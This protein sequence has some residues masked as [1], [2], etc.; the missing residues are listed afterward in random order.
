[1][2]I[3]DNATIKKW[4]NLKKKMY[5]LFYILNSFFLISLYGKT[6]CQ[7][8]RRVCWGS[9]GYQFSYRWQAAVLA[10]WYSLRVGGVMS[11]GS[12]KAEV[13]HV[14]VFSAKTFRELNLS[15]KCL[16]VCLWQRAGITCTAKS[17]K[18]IYQVKF[19]S[20]CRNRWVI[21][22]SHHFDAIALGP[23]LATSRRLSAKFAE[24]SIG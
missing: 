10:N 21:A 3:A 11:L 20:W 8:I 15:P 14:R 18:F 24:V 23:W 16:H 19:S 7:A 6:I 2:G 1:M 9:H 5:S 13:S 12:D 4:K 22:V 17:L